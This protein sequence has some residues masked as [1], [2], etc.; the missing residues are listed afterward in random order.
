MAE[1]WSKQVPQM[2]RTVAPGTLL[3][4]GLENVLRAKTGGL[5]VIGVSEELMQLVD[6]GFAIDCEFT[7]SHL[8]ELSKMDGAI[9]MNDEGTRI[10]YANTQLLPDN[11]I[12]S[13]ETG[14]RHRT[15]ERVAKQTGH[16]VISISQR[17]NIITL[18]KGNLQ[19]ELKE[20][21]VIL[22]KATQA[23]RTLERYRLV[24]NQEL[25][26][27]GA[28]EFEQ[29]VTM[30]E[31]ISVIQR[32][33]IVLRINEEI[34]RLV[35]ELGS[36]GRLVQ[37]QLVDLMKGVEVEARLLLLDYHRTHKPDLDLKEMF[38]YSNK[39]SAKLSDNEY[40]DSNRILK[41]LGYA[42]GHGNKLSDIVYPRGYRLLNKVPRLRDR[43]SIIGKLIERFERF[44]DMINASHE[45]LD[46][47]EGISPQ[48]ARGIQEGLQKLQDQ[49][50]IERK[51]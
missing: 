46:K 6:G 10:L 11:S 49:L 51:L 39:S 18:Y 14:I 44:C 13:D 31:V 50:T 32:F 29:M 5:I 22:T 3:R 25:N 42:T 21:S 24:L 40:I 34:S 12:P 26:E 4:E 30:T 41:L 47:V 7:P 38:D 48:F 37:M 8:Y 27:L 15:A 33:D 17:R 28:L 9:L 19:L 45:E 1:Q 2:V 20:I 36:E 23:L 35:A 16:L 43:A